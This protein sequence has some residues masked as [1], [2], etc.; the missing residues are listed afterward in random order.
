VERT[1][2]QVTVIGDANLWK[3]DIRIYAITDAA[4]CLKEA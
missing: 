3:N 2:D 1:P 4:I